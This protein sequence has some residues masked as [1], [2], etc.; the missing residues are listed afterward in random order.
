MH[1]APSAVEQALQC[2]QN[3]GD[4]SVMCLR[5]PEDKKEKA[6]RLKAEAEAREAGKVRQL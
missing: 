3:D 4:M 6:E 1:L 2:A 5:R